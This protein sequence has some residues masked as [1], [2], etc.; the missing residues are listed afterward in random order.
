MGFLLAEVGHTDIVEIALVDHVM[1]GEGVAE[2][3]IGLVEGHRVDCVLIGRIAGDQRFGI[4]RL[5][6]R[7][8]QIV[9]HH[10]QAQAGE[11][12]GQR[13]GFIFAGH[14]YRLIDRVRCGER[15]VGIAC[16]V[17]VG[18]AKHVDLAIDQGANCSLARG[19][20][21]HANRQT[22]GLTENPCVIGGQSL[23]VLA[24]DGHVEWRV[25]RCGGTQF[26]FAASL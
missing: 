9:I 12:F 7:Q 15:E 22:G 25:I 20:A 10:A 2:K 5:D 4:Q 6:L 14:Q 18:C 8:R 26:Q 16:F 17:A 19:K 11:A 3:H 1:G 21:L 13:A 23:V 24:T